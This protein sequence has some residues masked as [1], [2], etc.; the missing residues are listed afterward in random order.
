M[1]TIGDDFGIPLPGGGLTDFESRQKL[2]PLSPLLHAI[3]VFPAMIGIAIALFAPSGFSFTQYFPDLLPFIA[4]LLAIGLAS[5]ALAIVVAVFQYF[6]WRVFSF[7]IDEDG[8]LRVR[9]GVFIRNERRVQLSRLQTVDVVQPFV[10]RIFSMATVVVEVAGQDNSR[11][12]F[13]F[14]TLTDARKIRQ[15]LLELTSGV[16]SDPAGNDASVL[17]RLPSRDLALALLLRTS[18]VLLLAATI[19]I[20]VFSYLTEGW[21]GMTF[22]LVTGGVPIL[23]VINE[24]ITYYGFTVFDSPEGLR[25]RYGL[26]KTENRTIPEGRVQAIDY[27]EPWLW[28]NRGW[29]RVVINIAGVGSTSQGSSNKA[30]ETLLLPVAEKKVAQELVARVLPQIDISEIQWHYAPKR[31]IRR[32]PIQWRNLAMGWNADSFAARRGRITRHLMV[33]PHARTQSVHMT[34][35]PWERV[36][37][38][39][40]LHIDTTPGPVTI[41]AYHLDAEL[42]SATLWEQSARGT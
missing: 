34:Q 26:L 14:L 18:T 25:L 42:V 22:A 7:W 6:S 2:H 39:A 31:A 38:L 16:R 33:I 36:L 13:R 27:V 41:C 21:A 40:S 23:I 17:F 3:S 1:T 8:D 24:F 5:M 11:V 29:T 20:L 37:K 35:G 19:A 9:S 15:R 10:A 4:A 12:S 28:R 30:K 32:S